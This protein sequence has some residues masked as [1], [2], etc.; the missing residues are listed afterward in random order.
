MKLTKENIALIDKMLIK[1]NGVIYIDIRL[2]LL[3]HLATELEQMDG[4]FE[5]MFSDF[6]ESKKDFI[7]KMN[8]QLNKQSSKKGATETVNR[9]AELEEFI[10]NMQTL[11]QPKPDFI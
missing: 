9:L 5:E 7:N 10:R 6:F 3:D 4:K 2:E 8:I 1:K 11:V